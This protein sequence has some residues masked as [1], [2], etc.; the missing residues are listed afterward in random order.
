MNLCDL[1]A[2]SLDLKGQA[3]LIV[4]PEFDMKQCRMQGLTFWQV[5][6]LDGGPWVT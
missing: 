3:D 5:C 1:M 6:V 2:L 4:R